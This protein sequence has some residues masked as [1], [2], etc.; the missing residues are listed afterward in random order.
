MNDGLTWLW[1]IGGVLA[2]WLTLA[3]FRR[4]LARGRVERVQDQLGATYAPIYEAYAIVLGLIVVGA[5]QDFQDAEA[6]AT[7]EASS[8]V[9]LAQLSGAFPEAQRLVIV[10]G[11][12]AYA[13][14]VVSSEWPAMSRREAPTAETQARLDDI[15]VRY[16]SLNGTPSAELPQYAASIDELDEL[17]DARSSRLLHSQRT[18]PAMLW[19]V[20][21]VGAVITVGFA[22]LFSI[23]DAPLAYA[24]VG[25]I[26]AIIGLL[27]V[28]GYDL[29][30]PYTG[31][32]QVDLNS[33]RHVSE[34]A[35]M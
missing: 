15:Y 26:A 22:Y 35:S 30:T 5:W 13:D 29:S 23:E 20:L 27:L 3:V 16:A 6:V 28:L 11:L 33:Y 34:A 2:A 4:K 17:D 7:S 1:V 31:P 9:N 25:T 19:V 18:M 21:I 32:T 8:I 14:S 24:V 12:K 10:D